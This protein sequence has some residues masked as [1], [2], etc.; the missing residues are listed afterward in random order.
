MIAEIIAVGSEMLTP[1]RQDTN[2]LALTA[3]LNQLGVQV[4]FKTIIGDSQKHLTGATLMALHRADIVVFSGGLGPTEDDL[5][6]NAVAAALEKKLERDPKLVLALKQRFAA[7]KQE[8]PEINLRQADV[9]E[10]A[11]SL[12]NANG[13]APGQF[14][15]TVHNGYRKLLILLP[16]PPREQAPMFKE[17]CVPKLRA[18]LPQRHIAT[19]SLRIALAPESQIDARVSPI[20]KQYPDVDTTILFNQQGEIQLHFACSKPTQEEAEDRVEELAGKCA[21]ELDDLVFAH[22]GESLEEVVLLMLG[23]RHLT[24]STAESCTGGLVAERLTRIPGS[25]RA[26]LGGA[27][28][29]SDELKTRFANVPKNLIRTHGAVSREV[30]VSLAEGIRSTTGTDIGIGITGIA[31]PGGATLN[32]PVG[33]VYVALASAEGSEVQELN[34][35]GERERVRWFSSQHALDMLRRH[36]M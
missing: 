28:V 32:K 24:L 9:I 19:R 29:Y 34:L 18:L 16:G 6:R 7:R 21:Q 36:L 8:M 27:V 15:D 22:E 5:T 17:Q 10:G 12:P 31:G 25:S 1:H 14:L 23:M 3:E 11:E 2:S 13:S 20:Y 35:T 33:R 4:A 26:F 30:A